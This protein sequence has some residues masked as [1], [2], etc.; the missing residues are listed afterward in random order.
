MA[1]INT[2]QAQQEIDKKASKREKRH[3][4]KMK[5]SG[6]GV[7]KLLQIKKSRKH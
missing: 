3:R 5:V 6:K 4:P 2:N 7:R 1:K